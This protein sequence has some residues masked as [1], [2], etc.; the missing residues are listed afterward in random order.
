LQPA[1]V[2]SASRLSSLN[3]Y[4]SGLMAPTSGTNT[5]FVARLAIS[6]STGGEQLPE[7]RCAAITIAFFRRQNR[8]GQGP[9]GGSAVI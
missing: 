5:T 6:E 2:K 9:S 4:A 8:R 3:D 1:N 7:R